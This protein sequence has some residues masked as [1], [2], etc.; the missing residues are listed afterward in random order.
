MYIT[1]LCIHPDT[2]FPHTADVAP[3]FPKFPFKICKGVGPQPC[4]EANDLKSCSSWER[5]K[6][7]WTAASKAMAGAMH[8]AQK[9]RIVVAVRKELT[10]DRS[11]F[12][13]ILYHTELMFMGGEM[14]RDPKWNPSLE[15]H[16]IPMAEASDCKVA[17][18]LKMQL[19]VRAGREVA[20]TCA[21]CPRG[22]Q[23]CGPP[24]QVTAAAVTWTCTAG[25]CQDGQGTATFA[26]GDRYEGDFKNGKM[27][28]RGKYFSANGDRYEGDFKNGDKNGKGKYFATDGHRYEGDFKNGQPDGNGKYFYG[29]G[30]RHEGA[31]KN[32]LPDGKGKYFAAS[33]N[34][35]EGDFKNGEQHG[36]GK[37]FF[38][39]GD[40]YEGDYRNDQMDGKGK[41]FSAD[42]DRYE[43]DFKNGEQHGKGKQFFAGGD[44]YEG[45]F[46][47][48]K[49]DG[50]GKYFYASGD[51]E[52]CVFE[53]GEEVNCDK[54]C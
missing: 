11:I 12:N 46:K 6:P 8:Q 54:S 22:L 29:D 41:Y 3:K 52:E 1:S 4:K 27:D 34:R 35:Y 28:G 10:G 24:R 30:D 14:S 51:C 36:K 32:G 23:A 5:K 39:N 33:G 47:D 9:D 48:G 31:F 13:S 45:D 17:P 19:E 53:M 25:D 37:A 16:E 50:K 26:D 49:W 43:G 7:F 44:R 20:M 21:L 40:R 42:G 18:W 2:G 38:A 15:V